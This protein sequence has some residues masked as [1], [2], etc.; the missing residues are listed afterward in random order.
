MPRNPDFY[1]GT[2]YSR[3]F[4]VIETELYRELQNIAAADPRRRLKTGDVVKVLWELSKEF[5]PPEV[6]E[7][8][9]EQRRELLA[10]PESRER[11]ERREAGE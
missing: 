2:I 5:V 8:A 10:P 7:A 3:Q 1:K 4:F 11:S 6:F 9:V